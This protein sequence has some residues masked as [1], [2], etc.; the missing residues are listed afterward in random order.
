M[1]NLCGLPESAGGRRGNSVLTTVGCLM[2][3]ILLSLSFVAVIFLI[4]SC[5]GLPGGTTGGG[6]SSTANLSITLLD[7]PP[8]GVD[9]VSFNLPIV[10]ISLTSASTGGL[11]NVFSPSTIPSF[12]LVRLQSDSA[13]LGTFQVPVD[14][15]NAMT[16]TF[17]SPSTIFANSTGSTIGTCPTNNICPLN[18]GAGSVV[19][20]ISPALQVSSNTGLG[21]DFNL[22]NIVSLSGNARPFR[23]L[24]PA[25]PPAR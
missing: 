8:A 12:D 1:T 9:F 20:P 24:A 17:G 18:G 22:N 2:K 7:T 19:V 16:I 14:S 15:Y 11:V 4:S 6:G 3:R 21:I 23:F 10:G 13:D 25:K 5:S